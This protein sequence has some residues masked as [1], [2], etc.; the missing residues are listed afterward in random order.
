MNKIF[1]NN[2][3]KKAEFT[4]SA[5]K[6]CSGCGSDLSSLNSPSQSRKSAARATPAPRRESRIRKNKK[7][8]VQEELSGDYFVESEMSEFEIDSILENQSLAGS[9]EVISVDNGESLQIGI[10]KKDN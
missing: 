1:C 9:M 2:C 4:H 3:G 10:P 6:F 8:E 7:E 5:P